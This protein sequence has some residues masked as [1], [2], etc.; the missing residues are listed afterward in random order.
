MR[1]RRR[2]ILRCCKPRRNRCAS[3]GQAQSR[4][5]SGKL[6]TRRGW[7]GG[8]SWGGLVFLELGQKKFSV[9][10]IFLNELLKQVFV[11]RII[12]GESD[13]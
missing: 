3:V 9:Q 2:G 12:C 5:R 1:R 7:A 10:V 6:G 11:G 13:A 8:W 4:G